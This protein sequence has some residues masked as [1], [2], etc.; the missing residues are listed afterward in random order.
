M[1]CPHV[2]HAIVTRAG[3]VTIGVPRACGASLAKKAKAEPRGLDVAG[4]IGYMPV[5]MLV[6]PLLRGS[7]CVGAPQ[8]V[9]RRD[10]NV[11]DAGDLPRGMLFAELAA[12]TLE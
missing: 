8:I 4:E 6:V 10:G 2:R 3:C 5:T 9:D 12:A 1:G 7:R 11:Y